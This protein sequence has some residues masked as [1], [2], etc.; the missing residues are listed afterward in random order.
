MSFLSGG[1][2]VFGIQWSAKEATAAVFDL[3]AVNPNIVVKD[4]NR[5]PAEVIRNIEAEGQAVLRSLKTL[6]ALLKF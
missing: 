2:F 6:N 4:D 5:S 1:S 3:K